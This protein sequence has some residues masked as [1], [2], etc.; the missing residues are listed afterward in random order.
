MRWPHARKISTRDGLI[1]L[2]NESQVVLA[3]GLIFEGG[4][5]VDPVGSQDKSY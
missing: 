2:L 5:Y 1:R 3:K 4:S